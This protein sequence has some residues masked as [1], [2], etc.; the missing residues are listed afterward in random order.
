MHLPD[1]GLSKGLSAGMNAN[2]N[3]TN[4]S[5]LAMCLLNGIFSFV[6]GKELGI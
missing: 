3:V 5:G 1:V 6:E 4:W 2:L